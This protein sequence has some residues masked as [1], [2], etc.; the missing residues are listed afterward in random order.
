MSRTI[1]GEKGPGYEYWKSRLHRYGEIP[2]PR[3]KRI[4]NRRERHIEKQ[5]LQKL[6]NKINREEIC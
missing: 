3:T 4:T 5:E 1:R 2:G 6:A